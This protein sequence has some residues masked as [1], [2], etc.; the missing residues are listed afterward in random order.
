MPSRYRRFQ[1]E[2]PIMRSIMDYFMVRRIYCERMNAGEAHRV[3]EDGIRRTIKLHTEGIS[4]L[5]AFP[6]IR[7]TMTAIPLWVECKRDAKAERRATQISFA[8]H[9]KALGMHYMIAWNIE[10]VESYM[11]SY[12]LCGCGGF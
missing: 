2:T 11:K 5:L 12:D 4:D 10:G 6:Y 9:M 7:A 1:P 3:G 8:N